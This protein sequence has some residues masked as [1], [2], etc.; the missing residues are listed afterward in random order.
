[1]ISP[2]SVI[3]SV[4]ISSDAT[5]DLAIMRQTGATVVGFDPTIS[6]EQF[7]EAVRVASAFPRAGGNLTADEKR[8]LSFQPFGLGTSDTV[9]PFYGLHSRTLNTPRSMKQST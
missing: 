1:M 5:F 9:L 4:G 3:F 6:V 7:W 8:R 2:E